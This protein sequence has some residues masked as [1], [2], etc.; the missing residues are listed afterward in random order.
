M[1]SMNI[2]A[3]KSLSIRANMIW[4]A[5]GSL[6]YMAAQWLITVLVVRLSTGYD[7]AGLLALGMAVSNIFSPIGYYK[8]RTYQVS[9]LDEE[10]TFAQYL[11]FRI[12]TV[13]LAIGV[14]F[15]Y[16]FLTCPTSAWLTVILYGFFSLGPVFVDVLHGEEQRESR[17]DVIGISFILRGIL[18][19]VAFIAGMVFFNSLDIALILMTVSTYLV[20]A[21]FDGMAFLKVTHK[22]LKP[23]FD[24]VAI[25]TLFVKCLPLVVASFFCWAVPA[26][27]RQALNDVMGEWFLGIYSSVAAPVLIVQMCA[28]YIYAPLL[29]RFAEYLKAGDM[30]G[31]LRLVFKVSVAIFALALV[32]G[33]LFAFVGEPVLVLIFGSSIAPY[34]YL[35]V[36]LVLC[37]VMTA[38]VWFLGDVLITMRRNRENLAGYAISFVLILASMYLMIHA[39]EMNGVS[40]AI[41]LAYGASILF[42]LGCM[43]LDAKKRSTAPGE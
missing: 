25:R 28:Q 20:I 6:V 32:F 26:I 1:H 3:D 38:Y 17:M 39:F 30:R 11:G 24:F 35:I 19:L 43:L 41:M 10:F 31:F 22:P 42:F 2:G 9:D 16:C 13:A 21:L 18:L 15:V 4:N 7:A 36:P 29:T 27:P 37:T 12:I 14:M 40:F 34:A 8:I 33:L 5:A 23:A